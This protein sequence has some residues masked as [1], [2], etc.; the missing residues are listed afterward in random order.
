MTPNLRWLRRLTA[1]VR[2]DR[3]QQDIDDEIL[4]HIESRTRDYIAAGMPDGEARRAAQRLFGNRTVTAER[5]RDIDV[6]RRIDAGLRNVRHAMRLLWRNPGFGALVV[7]SM[8]LGIGANTAVFSLLNAVVLKKL[9]VKNPEELVILEAHVGGPGGERTALDWN[10]DLRN[11]QAGAGQHIDLFTTSETGAVTT[12]NGG[13]QK[14]AIGLV[15]GNYYSAVG[16]QP[17]VGR[18]I[19]PTDDQP[20]DPQLVAVL[21]YGFWRQRFG[22]D[23]NVVGRQ[24]VLNG[25]S[26]SIVG[27]TPRGFFGTAFGPPPG[28]TIP[29]Q[30][31]GRLDD[32]ISFRT[33]GGRLRPGVSRQQATAVLT[34]IFQRAEHQ[35]NNVIVLQDNSRGE[36]RDRDRFQKPLYVLMAGVVLVLLI[37]AANVASLLLARGTARQ[38]EISIRLALGA[39]RGGV[40]AQLL[41]ESVLIALLGAVVGIA[42]AYLAAGALLAMLGPAS[43]ALPLDIRPD[44]RVLVFTTCTAVFTGLLFGL[45]PAFQAGRTE[46]N[47]AL[48]ETTSIVGR[49]PRPTARRALVVAQ[50]AL[51]LVLL[52]GAALF[53]RSLTNLRSFDSGYDRRGVLLATFEPDS[54]YPKE[55]LHQVQNDLL[56][57][58]RAIPGVETA[59]VASTP[60]LSPGEYSA[61]LEIP[62]RASE[63]PASMTIASAGYLETMRMQL[64]AGRMFGTADN[65]AGAPHTVVVNQELVRRCFPSSSPIGVRVTAGFGVTAEIVGVVTDAKYRD[66][67]E[68]SLPMYFVPPRAVHPYGLELHVRTAFDPH[69]AVEPIRRAL[70]ETDPAI[71]LTRVRTL[72]EQ[73]EASVVQDRLL[74][75]LSTA[76]SAGA[77]ALAAIGLYGVLAFA[78]ARRTNEIGLRMALGARPLQIVRLIVGE[79]SWM[80]AAG[81]VVGVAGAYAG[82]R[83]IGSLLFR[84]GPTDYWS[85]LT[86]AAILCAVGFCATVIPARQAIRID[87]IAALRH[88]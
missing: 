25:V 23:P 9:P 8:A 57:R 36:Y 64:V 51:S 68:D 5:V 21:D 61:A 31:E 80:M 24:I 53:T 1:L 45:F 35:R 19:V 10:R 16:V 32:G 71:P 87:P 20:G 79:S 46:L 69:G 28:I 27:V 58:V 62:G 44:V 6:S 52:S 75:T 50:I 78:V 39:G 55:R 77:L 65:Q 47:P 15:S 81:S 29:V 17:A 49:R 26:F 33:I 54:R 60:V 42:L 4:F 56:E 30:A 34:S 18:L 63:C 40:A 12:L 84:V 82:Q 11:F 2:R 3:L 7:L 41:T 48:K 22:A 59:G 85:L 70:H 76:F 83:V 13:A 73:S 74:A 38:R 67:R 37:A 72:E 86:A 43:T 88:E 14:I 66:L